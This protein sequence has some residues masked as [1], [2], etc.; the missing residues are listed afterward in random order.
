MENVFLGTELVEIGIQIEKNGRDFY[1]TLIGKSKNSEARQIFEFLAREEEKH[2]SVFQE[3]LGAVRQY[4]SEIYPEEY[5][6]YM[7]ALAGKYVFTQARKGEE[8]A[9]EINSDE[10]A[11][12]LGIKFEKDSIIFYEGIITAVKDEEKHLVEKIIKE[13]EKHLQTLIDLK[14]K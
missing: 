8:I 6:S 11:I 10:E 1:K 14:K 12:D 4:P 5:F 13:E 3:I 9:L 7:N 2:I